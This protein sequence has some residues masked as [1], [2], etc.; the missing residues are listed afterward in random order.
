MTPQ[1]KVFYLEK[2]LEM[3]YQVR[4]ELD[5]RIAETEEALGAMDRT[6]NGPTAGTV[7][8]EI[9]DAIYEVLETESPLHR[10]DI[11]ERV[12]ASGVIIGG[13]DKLQNLSA[14]L[15]EDR[16]FQPAERG[17][18]TLAGNLRPRIRQGSASVGSTSLGEDSEEESFAG[19]TALD[20]RSVLS[21]IED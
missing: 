6:R 8:A 3:L 12:E 16:R 13:K 9:T 21:H 11:L 20:E 7:A 4:A 1:F 14:Y 15:S 18:W 5:T 10:R 19:A 17:H 2:E